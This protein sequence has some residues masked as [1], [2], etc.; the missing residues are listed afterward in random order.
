[1]AAAALVNRASV[2]AVLTLLVASGAHGCR[3]AETFPDTD[4]APAKATGG[5]GGS[6]RGGSAG[7]ARPSGTGGTMGSA[8][9]GGATG[10]EVDA[11]P[12]APVADAAILIE[13][14]ASPDVATAAPDVAAPVVDVGSAPDVA[15]PAP[16]AA[17]GGIA[18]CWPDPKVIKIC[19]Q[20]ENACENCPPGGA[21]PK[22][23][24]AKK[25]DDL[26]TK[27]KAGKAT[28]AQCAKFA[29][30][31]KCPVD[32]K[33]TTGNVCGSLNCYVAGCTDK[34]RCLDR[35]QMGDSAMCQ[36]LM[37]TCG[38]CK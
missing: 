5:S 27:A 25:C 35:Q 28:D 30:D 4:I 10:A 18:I 29:V 17:P 16:D 6:G 19:R 36:P 24:L 7:G 8:A 14:G 31:N 13:A 34:A 20:L 11:D 9:S 23:A 1:M 22:N 15:G 32:N 33:T 37:A 21:A 3:T 2:L 38:P 26:V 12:V